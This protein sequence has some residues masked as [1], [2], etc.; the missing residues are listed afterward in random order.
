VHIKRGN[1]ADCDHRGPASNFICS[2]QCH[3][4]YLVLSDGE[5]KWGKKRN[6]IVWVNFYSKCT[7]DDT[8]MI[9]DKLLIISHYCQQKNWW[10]PMP[11]ALT[12]A[13]AFAR[14]IAVGIGIPYSFYSE[15][16]GR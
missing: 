16:R 1:A 10:L 5:R 11:T 6:N 9:S 14:A 2:W 13:C 4:W 7:L 8:E 15:V 3:G 12:F